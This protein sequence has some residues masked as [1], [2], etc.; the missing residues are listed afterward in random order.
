MA[1]WIVRGR[2]GLEDGFLVLL[3]RV[4]INLPFDWTETEQINFRLLQKV[5]DVCLKVVTEDN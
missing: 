3:E 2:G 4:I 5:Q 1:N